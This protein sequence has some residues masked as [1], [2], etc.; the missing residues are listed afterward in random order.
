MTHRCRPRRARHLRRV[1]DSDDHPI[2]ERLVIFAIH[3]DVDYGMQNI[4]RL[5]KDGYDITSLND[6]DKANH[7]D[8]WTKMRP[9]MNTRSG[10]TRAVGYFCLLAISLPFH[11][12]ASGNTEVLCFSSPPDGAIRLQLTLPQDDSQVAT[13]RYER[14][15]DNIQLVR[16]DDPGKSK[17]NVKPS[18]AVE[19]TFAE[20]VNRK[21]AGKYLLTTRDG[22][23][24]NLVY[25][26]QRDH[27]SFTFYLD[28]A[29]AAAGIC[30]WLQHPPSSDE[31]SKGINQPACQPD[32]D[33]SLPDEPYM[34]YSMTGW[35]GGREYD[36]LWHREVEPISTPGQEPPLFR[37]KRKPGSIWSSIQPIDL[38]GGAMGFVGTRNGC[39]QLLDHRGAPLQV[40][41]FDRIAEDYV[42][43]ELLSAG[44]VLFRLHVGEAYRLV[45]F[46][47]GQKIAVS[48]RTYLM[49]YSGS[50][51]ESGVLPRSLLRLASRFND[52]HG[53]VDI[54]SLEEV[55]APEWRGITGI[56]T[57][58]GSSPANYLMTER[59]GRRALFSLSGKGPL[60][61]GIATLKVVNDWFP[62][63]PGRSAIDRAVLVVGMADE[64]GAGCRL[65]DMSLKPL[66]PQ[67][68]PLQYQQ[69]VLP[70]AGSKYLFTDAGGTGVHIYAVKPEGSLQSIGSAPGRIAAI[71]EES[72]LVLVQV[73]GDQQGSAYRLYTVEGQ[74][75]DNE[76]YTGFRHLGCR[77]YEVSANGR[78]LTLMHDGT[79]SE[80][81]YHPFSC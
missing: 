43:S 76:E 49:S 13:V 68:L 23:A 45:R 81:R 80:R 1:V 48:K 10:R 7:R 24:G 58:M 35:K 44:Q 71:L 70:S 59:G 2:G 60:L 29:S 22:V 57:G 63:A 65:L 73:D 72:G 20:L 15:S 36:K 28:R 21:P 40:P 52:G 18:G 75:F 55:L 67:L 3:T 30:N 41:L 25:V 62:P 17:K 77:F 54:H 33:A 46:D 26:R 8:G 42:G 19:T 79:T 53:L 4:N 9:T 34:G 11:A 51:L 5:I 47:R 12:L 69:C 56:G 31:G 78:W 39:Q 74:R 14:G 50:S 16:Q 6:A 66:L 32:P 64:A 38:G 27:R 37:F 61:E